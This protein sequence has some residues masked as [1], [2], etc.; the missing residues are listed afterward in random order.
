M[1]ARTKPPFRADH[2]GSLLR[3]T[4]LLRARA[5][6]AA[7]KLSDAEL[8]A[9]EDLAIRAAVAMQESIGLQSATDGE[10]RRSSWHMDFISQ[11][12]G[13][14]EAPGQLAVSFENEDERIEFTPPA[15]RVDKPISLN[16]TIFAEAFSALAQMV[17]TALPKLTIPSPSM[18]HY[19]GGNQA[20]IGAA[21]SEME[22]FWSDLAAAYRAEIAALSDLGCAYLQLDD[23]SLAYLNDPV[24][25]EFIASQ[26]G[27]PD[28]QHEEYI[29]HL[30]DALRDR[31]AS[32]TVTT[33]LCRGNFQSSWAAS[34][35]YDF[36][37]E[38]LFSDLNVDGYFLEFDDERSGGF[39]PLRFVPP[40]KT[41]ALGLVTTKRPAL[42]DKELLKRRVAEAARFVPLEQLCLAPQCG[43]ASTVEG[44]RLSEDDEVA[45]L[46]LIVETATEIWG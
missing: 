7:G 17:T 25:R 22:E 13:I 29:R 6:H 26:G 16:K 2:V 3:P 10:M 21:Y 30:N 23:T 9:E 11:L 43:F 35:S 20:I 36:V 18:V 27:D 33:H 32:M 12:G 8:R 24:Q 45:K 5:E 14:V 31:P 19:R 41:V 39:E 15:F 4:S 40:N 37:A 38:A 44:N 46:R 42:E 34:G 28:H 1:T